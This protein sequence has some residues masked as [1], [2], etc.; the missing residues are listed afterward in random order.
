M[1][2]IS[3]FWQRNI[4]YA[5]G[6]QC[7]GIFH[8]AQFFTL[9][10]TPRVCCV[11]K[12]EIP[13]VLG[14]HTLQFFMAP[15]V[16]WPEVMVEYEQTE[17]ILFSADGFGKFGASDVEED[18]DDEARRYFYQHCRKIRN[19]GAGSVKESRYTGY[20]DDLPAPR[21]STERGPGPL[22][23]QISYLEQLR[24]RRRRG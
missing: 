9:D 1:L 2:P 15:M 10:F 11:V 5:G 18:W 22:Y 13:S 12:K 3:S 16:H 23:R 7:E 24:T 20:P 19:P 17:K 21:T 14:N 8:A 6:F 4:G